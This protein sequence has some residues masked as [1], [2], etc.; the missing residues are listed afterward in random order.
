MKPDISTIA[1][2]VNRLNQNTS[3]SILDLGCGDGH[4]LFSI[5]DNPTFHFEKLI[6]VDSGKDEHRIP[7]NDL[8]KD[9]EI[10]VGYDRK[11]DRKI[12]HYISKDLNDYINSIDDKF[13]LIILSN[14]LHFFE[15]EYVLRILDR[16]LR[17]L[18]SESLLYMK[19]A[20][21]KHP[22]KDER[23]KTVLNKTKYDLLK[24]RFELIECI[25]REESYEIL[26]SNYIM[27]E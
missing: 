15:W 13:D 11:L 26:I 17:L 10:N 1:L 24:D 18:K 14:V 9:Y 21:E 12:F 16:S 6:G 25:E 19:M 23:D 20:G 5:Y 27:S 2:L 7:S 3:L 22:Y 4:F 8:N